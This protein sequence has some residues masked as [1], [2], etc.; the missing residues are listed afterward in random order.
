MRQSYLLP[1]VQAP[2][3]M[4]PPE[5][6]LIVGALRTLE[7]PLDHEAVDLT[8]AAKLVHEETKFSAQRCIPFEVN[9]KVELA[10]RLWSAAWTAW[11][12]GQDDKVLALLEAWEGIPVWS[13]R[14]APLLAVLSSGWEAEGR[15]SKV[16]VAAMRLWIRLEGGDGPWCDLPPEAIE[17]WIKWGDD[18]TVTQMTDPFLR[19]CR[20]MSCRHRKGLHVYMWRCNGAFRRASKHRGLVDAVVGALP[21]VYPGRTESALSATARIVRKTVN[22]LWQWDTLSKEERAHMFMA[23]E[24]FK[25]YVERKNKAVTEA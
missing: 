7:R 12:H 21:R 5:D 13:G 1:G 17:Q 4:L 14:V 2:S 20:G 6:V 10:A 24:A 8:A 9:L 25:R 3:A 19:W 15:V 11:N 22:N 18:E 16:A 23:A